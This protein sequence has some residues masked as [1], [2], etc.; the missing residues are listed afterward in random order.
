MG[1][2]K[3]N[4]L[5][6]GANATEVMLWSERYEDYEALRDGLYQEFTP[7]GSTEEYLVQKLLDLRWRRRRLECHEQI[8][9]QQRLD[10]VR[11]KNEYS[12]H[13][14]NLRS[15]APE[16]REAT[17]EE[18]VEA[19]LATLSPIYRNT[20]RDQWPF[21]SGDESQKWGPLI[22]EGLLAWKPAPRYEQADE[23]IKILDLDEFDTSLERIERLDAMID[24]TIK[25]LMQLK[26]MKQMH[27]RLEPKLIE[28]QATKNLQAP[29]RTESPSNE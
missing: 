8:V 14:D 3:R 29:G 19:R 5:K 23:F 13:V 24:R 1:K 18:Q 11:A 16:F 10:R 22:A 7:S 17:S 26:T 21:K 27:G 12:Y 6:H 25:R 28:G 20:I 15:F 2:K 4:A 9:I